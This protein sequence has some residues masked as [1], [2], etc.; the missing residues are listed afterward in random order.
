MDL[1]K[2]THLGDQFKNFAG[3]LQKKRMDKKYDSKIA[4]EHHKTQIKR[5]EPF[6]IENE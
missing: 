6:E 1:V 2:I 5:E 4:K 3:V